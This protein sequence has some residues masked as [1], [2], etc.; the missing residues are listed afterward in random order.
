MIDFQSL[1]L[2]VY[3]VG[4]DQEIME[5]NVFHKLVSVSANNLKMLA[6]LIRFGRWENS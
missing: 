1:R 3:K 5:R 6:V 2:K 4:Q